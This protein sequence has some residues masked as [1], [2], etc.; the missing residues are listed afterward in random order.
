MGQSLNAVRVDAGAL[1][2]RLQLLAS[3]LSAATKGA[4]HRSLAS[5]EDGRVEF[6][7]AV[8]SSHRGTDTR[9]GEREHPADIRGRNE[10]PR[11]RR[12]GRA[13]RVPDL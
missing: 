13:P 9:R 6:E 2:D 10:V 3:E 11:T 4:D 1:E 12:M 5:A 8:R 7:A